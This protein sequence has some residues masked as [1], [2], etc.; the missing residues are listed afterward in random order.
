[1]YYAS[2]NDT[3]KNWLHELLLRDARAAQVQF[4]TAAETFQMIQESTSILVRYGES[5]KWIEQLRFADPTRG[6]MRR[7]QRCTVSVHPGLALKLLERGH[8]EE[9]QPGIFAQTYPGLYHEQTGLD[10]YSET[11]P[12]EDLIS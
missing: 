2:V 9:I 10:L 6:L 3:G 12:I 11:L 4:R 5:S 7:L 1:M 8:I